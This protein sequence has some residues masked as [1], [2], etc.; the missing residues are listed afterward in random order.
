VRDDATA[1]SLG[2]YAFEANRMSKDPDRAARIDALQQLISTGMASGEAQSL[3]LLSFLSRMRRRLGSIPKGS[4][5]AH[6]GLPKSVAETVDCKRY[7]VVMGG[8]IYIPTDRKDYLMVEHAAED[9]DFLTTNEAA[10]VAGA[11]VRLVNR[12]FDEDILPDALVSTAPVRRIRSGACVFVRFYSEAEDI[13]TAHERRAVIEYFCRVDPRPV[14]WR[15]REW[16]KARPRLIY[17]HKDLMTLDFDHLIEDT[18]VGHRKLALSN[19]MV[20]EDPKILGG[21][22]VIKGTRIPVYDVAA[23]AASGLS[24]DEIREDYPNLDREKIELAIFYAKA[25][26]RRGRPKSSPGRKEVSR[27]I[28]QRRSG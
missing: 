11:D 20:V 28:I 19:A 24:P 18:L 21:T 10:A 25:N 7:L 15:A 23:S 27:K 3:D 16:S 5:N 1:A 17:R 6:V 12:L 14:A 2:R 13:L 26:P 8:D 9:L 22:P 4:W